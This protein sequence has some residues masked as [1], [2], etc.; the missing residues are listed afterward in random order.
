M[1][2]EESDHITITASE[3]GERIDKVLTQRYEGK[4]SRTYFQYLIDEKLI[5]LNGVPVKK[6]DKP[7]EGDEIEVE[8]ILTPEVQIEAE[9]I[10][11]DIIF[12]DP[13]LIIVNKPSGMVVHPATGNWTGTFVNALLYHC[14]QELPESDSL[15]PGIVHRLDKDTSGLLIAAK[16]SEAHRALIDLFASRKVYKEYLA[17]CIG[18]P[19]QCV[20][21]EPIA[22]HPVNRQKM[23]VVETG[24]EAI[25]EI[26]T[27]AFNESLALVQAILKTG[28]THQIRVHLKYKGCPVVGDTLYGS[29]QV[30][31][32]YG[33]GRQL[34]HAY[35]LRF[36][37]PIT[38][39]QIDVKASLYPDMQRFIE[40]RINKDINL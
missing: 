37:H 38:K 6:R 4:Y 12:E 10:P 9:A 8:F 20:I 22:R 17:V 13:H 33:I 29:S 5:L 3:A 2:S 14:K 36:E 21:N 35:R 40:G 39:E 16:T 15:R 18:N 34:L 28:R 27:L 30:N 31:T 19:G 1:S 26:R 32:K 11:L 23:A 7:Q 25:T 24:K